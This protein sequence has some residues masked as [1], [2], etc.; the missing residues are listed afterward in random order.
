RRDWLDASMLLSPLPMAL[1]WIIEVHRNG[2]LLAAD[3]SLAGLAPVLGFVALCAMV[4]TIIF[5]RATTRTLKVGTLVACAV[6]L[7]STAT[8]LLDPSGGLVSV[9]G[10][11]VILLA[12]LLSPALVARHA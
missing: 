12:F 10:R 2:G 7:V 8:L 4:A 6:L 9:A 11:S 5:L 1:I 3:A